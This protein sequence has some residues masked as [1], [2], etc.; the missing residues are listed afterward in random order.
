M[1]KK[2]LLKATAIAMAGEE[3]NIEISAKEVQT[4][5]RV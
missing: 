2:P 1:L 5:Q 4:N 3:V